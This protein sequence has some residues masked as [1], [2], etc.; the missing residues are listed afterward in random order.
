MLR[1]HNPPPQH[2]NLPQSKRHELQQIQ[3]TTPEAINIHLRIKETNDESTTANKRPFRPNS[4]D[5]HKRW[6]RLNQKR[7]KKP[8]KPWPVNI[9]L[10][11]RPP[12]EIR[13]SKWT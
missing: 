5:Q 13:Q 4:N 7:H 10:T 3:K 2:Q 8:S 9:H 1:K 6:T 11:K 12:S